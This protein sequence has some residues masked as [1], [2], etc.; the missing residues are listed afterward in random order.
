MD[1][2]KVLDLIRHLP[3]ILRGLDKFKCPL[4]QPV[5]RHAVNRLVSG[6]GLAHLALYSAIKSAGNV[7]TQPHSRHLNCS[8]V[9]AVLGMLQDLLS[10]APP[11]YGE[12]PGRVIRFSRT[13]LINTSA[14]QLCQ[15]Q[16]APAVGGELGFH[17]SI[18]E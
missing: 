14:N 6:H 18:L 4:L 16:Q 7:D 15:C 17:C 2:E 11:Q 9:H 3:A 13:V 8:P 5:T 10:M 1:F 12:Y